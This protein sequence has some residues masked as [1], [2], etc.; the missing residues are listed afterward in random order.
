MP[1]SSDNPGRDVLSALRSVFDL[2]AT[3][4][5]ALAAI[6]ILWRLARPPRPAF[7]AVRM[8]S[9]PVST[10]GAPTIG[11]PAASVALIE[12]TDYQCPVCERFNEDPWP[13]LKRSFVDTGKVLVVFR[14]LP[15]ERIHPMALMEAEYAYCGQEQQ[16][17]WPMHLWLLQHQREISGAALMDEAM[18]VGL[19][20]KR[21]DACLASE[22]QPAIQSELANAKVLAISS[23]PTFFI[24]R[25]ATGDE[26]QVTSR[27]DGAAQFGDFSAAIDRASRAR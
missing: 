21:L 4:L 23:T 16:R 17:F 24:G 15:L 14:H 12:Y 26:V 9:G 5:L 22:A 3:L 7:S 2:V 13:A 8:P 10:K 27:L 18:D 1:S 20:R 25:R 6:A 19:E 11:S